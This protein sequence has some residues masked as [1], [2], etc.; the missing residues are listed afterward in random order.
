M[1]GR[2][3]H[4]LPMRAAAISPPGVDPIGI[5]VAQCHLDDD[6]D[7]ALAAAWRLLSPDEAARARRF[8]FDRDR[9][10]YARGRGFLRSLLGQ[11]CGQHPA[12]LIFGI[13][14]QGKPFLQD[15]ALFFNLSHSRDLAVLAVSRMGPVG[16]DVE[17]ID[18]QVDLA[19][20]AQTCLTPH[21]TAVLDGLSETDRAARFFAFWTAKEA[22]MKL[23]GEGMLLPPRQISLDLHEGR[24]IGY[25]HPKTPAAQAILLDLGKTGTLCCLALA[26]G[27]RPII[28]RLIM[29]D[30]F[31]VTV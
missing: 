2:I 25:L 27:P 8:H 31:D 22:R 13:G 1:E 19:G 23:T 3:I 14:P 9:D 17:F 4:P 26:Q 16:L 12:G 6:R 28:T 7:M 15:H 24:P 11:F 30:A 20:L 18:R 5:G 21:E 10:R 29:E